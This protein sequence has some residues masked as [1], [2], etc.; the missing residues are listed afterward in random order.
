[1]R[2]T[3]GTG[4]KGTGLGFK[5]R[6][7]N[8]VMTCL[9]KWYLVPDYQKVY[10]FFQG[11]LTIVDPLAGL[12]AILGTRYAM[13]LICRDQKTAITKSNI[14]FVYNWNTFAA[15][16]LSFKCAVAMGYGNLL[17]PPVL[18]ALLV[19][20]PLAYLITFC[21]ETGRWLFAWPTLLFPA[22]ISMA[23]FCFGLGVHP[24]SLFSSTS[25][26]HS[27]GIMISAGLLIALMMR[28]PLMLA[29]FLI[30]PLPALAL[31][32]HDV[33][34][35][36]GS[37]AFLGALHIPRVP[38]ITGLLWSLF[39]AVL[40]LLSASLKVS[41]LQGT[42]YDQ[43]QFIFAVLIGTAL[44]V[45]GEYLTGPKIWPIIWRLQPEDRLDQA[46]A[47][48]FRFRNW[49]PGI[50]CPFIGTWS[51]YQ[52]F[53]GP[54]TH[55]GTLQHALDFVKLGSNGLTYQN[56]GHDLTDY[57]AFGQDLVAPVS[58][59]LVACYDGAIDQPIG[60]VDNEHRWGNF[61]M[62]RDDYGRYVT[63]AHIKQY[64]IKFKIN[65]YIGQG[66]MIAQCGN[67]GYSPEPHIHIQVQATPYLGQPTLPFYLLNYLETGSNT[68]KWF[69]HGVPLAGTSVTNPK[70]NIN[71]ERSLSFVIGDTFIFLLENQYRSKTHQ[72]WNDENF[73]LTN[74]LDQQSGL[75]YLTDGQARLYHVKHHSQIIFFDYQGPHEHPL[76]DLFI[77]A[78][79]IP[80]AYYKN[81]EFSESFFGIVSQGWFRRSLP[82]GTSAVDFRVDCV[83]MRLQSNN[84][85]LGLETFCQLDPGEGITHFGV[86]S[87]SYG[88]IKQNRSLPVAYP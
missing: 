81:F 38:S 76:K 35:W 8:R 12:F 56:Y 85:I 66:Q 26:S 49:Q 82:S 87:R 51:V 86:G 28:S 67:S 14:N 11:A 62:I 45:L 31:G 7:K 41:P 42:A 16:F 71:L 61:M 44:G 24:P 17:D 32:F 25:L 6:V 19:V 39:A 50:S 3:I 64:S 59:T 83:A 18:G 77:A 10:H 65:D 1:M 58:G 88:V 29:S 53:C 68:S 20:F 48:L 74:C 63:I 55:Q 2:S 52:G 9:N 70:I 60:V 84:P 23:V 37:L 47:I 5:V 43:I 40:A 22:F 54:W 34:I 13:G 78:P 36:I 80:M 33:R 27:I 4:Q 79:R 30:A 72:T 15:G 73:V 57:Y 75:M 21:F 46:G 69:S